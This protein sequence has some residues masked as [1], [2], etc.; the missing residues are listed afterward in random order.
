[1]S[2]VSLPA[3]PVPAGTRGAADRG[4][5]QGAPNP[6]AHEQHPHGAAHHLQPPTGQVTAPTALSFPLVAGVN[7]ALLSSAAKATGDLLSQLHGDISMP[8]C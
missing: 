7:F 2:A 4:G 5:L 1:M 8:K 3:G 6:E